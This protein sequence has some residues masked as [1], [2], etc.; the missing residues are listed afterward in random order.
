MSRSPFAIRAPDTMPANSTKYFTKMRPRRLAGLSALSQLI[1]S[2]REGPFVQPVK[3]EYRASVGRRT[4]AFQ[5][6]IEGCGW[7]HLSALYV[8]RKHINSRR[9][10]LGSTHMGRCAG[11]LAGLIVAVLVVT[12]LAAPALAEKRV[13]LVIGNG[14]YEQESRLLN[15]ANDARDVAASLQR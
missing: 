9:L 3:N 8:R 10:R 1:G 13:A 6:P 14:A 7:R 5:E 15:P 12:G 4:A 2:P 11:H